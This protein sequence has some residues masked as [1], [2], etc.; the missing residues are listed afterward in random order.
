MACTAGPTGTSC[1]SN[2]NRRV[3]IG[4]M[5]IEEYIQKNVEPELRHNFYSDQDDFHSL[6]DSHKIIY[7]VSLWSGPSQLGFRTLCSTSAQFKETHI[8]VL[9][10]DGDVEGTYDLIPEE[11]FR[12]ADSGVTLFYRNGE[13]R[14]V[15]SGQ[16][17]EALKNTLV[18]FSEDKG[19]H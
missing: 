6:N 7:I 5:T 12:L 18:E 4:L 9:V 11:H 1:Q 15:A 13:L 19:I 3:G 17:C 16:D 2:G 10:M 14:R 8:P